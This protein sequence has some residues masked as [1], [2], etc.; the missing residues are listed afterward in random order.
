MPSVDADRWRAMTLQLQQ[1]AEQQDWSRVQKLDQL[2]QQWLQ[3]LSASEADA[4]PAADKALLMRTHAMAHQACTEAKQQA[5]VQL[6][7][8]ENQQ[9]A[10]KAYAWQEVLK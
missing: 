5:R 1:A 7:Q 3:Q 8:L 9:E 6:Q 10:Q 4:L 2:L